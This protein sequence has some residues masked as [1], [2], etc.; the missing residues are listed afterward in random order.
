MEH[1]GIRGLPLRLFHSYLSDRFQ[2]L[3]I[4]NKTSIKKLSEYGLPQGTVLSP[5]LFQIYINDLL[6]LKIRNCN[7]I[8]FAD[9]TALVFTDRTWENMKITAE[10]GLRVVHSWL[11]E[12]LLT[13]NTDKSVFITFSPNASTQPQSLNT[14]KIHLLNCNSENLCSCPKINKKDNVKY[15]G[16]T[17]DPYLRWNTHIDNMCKKL[18]FLIYKFYQIKQLNNV[19]I[20]KLIYYSYAQSVLQYGIRA[21]GGA[22]NAHFNKLFIIQKHLIKT[23]LGKPRLYPTKYLFNEFKVL[24]VRQLYIKNLIIFIKNNRH[25]FLFRDT[26]LNLRPSR[27]R[28]E[29]I[30]M[31]L[32]VC[33][34]QYFYIA[35][36]LI[37]N[38]PDYLIEH[39]NGRSDKLFKRRSIEWIITTRIEDKIFD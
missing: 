18:R 25:L 21:W 38:I 10:N 24:T 2:I 11:N 32:N 29:N 12:H 1:L 39:I 19:N 13:L 28:F 9:D 17:I 34:R 37:N 31:D 33:R 4:N 26:N 30:R 14:I 15:L 23:I 27:K 5:I 22:L 6:K 16:I 20:T 7:I 36:K 3:T 35:N 8:S